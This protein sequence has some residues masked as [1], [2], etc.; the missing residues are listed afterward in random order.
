MWTGLSIARM[1]GLVFGK[2]RI[3]MNIYKVV[4]KTEWEF[5]LAKDEEE[6]KQSFLL[7][8]PGEE[9]VSCTFETKA[10]EAMFRALL[11]GMV[12]RI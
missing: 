3:G 9:V 2:E 4:G 1:L 7:A 6:A 8:F 5:W 10:E 11:N 12:M